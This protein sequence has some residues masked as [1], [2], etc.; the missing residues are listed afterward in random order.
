MS[1]AVQYGVPDGDHLAAHRRA[2]GRRDAAQLACCSRVPSLLVIG[3]V[4][5]RRCAATCG[6]PRRATS[7]RGRRTPA[8]TRTLTETVEGARTVEALGL[9]RPPGAGRRR[10]HRGVGAGRALHDDAAQPA[11][12]GHRR[13]LQHPARGHAAGRRLGLL[14]RLGLARAR[15]PPRCSTSRRSAVRSTGWS[16][17]STGCRS[18]PPRRA[19]CSASPRCRRT[20]SRAPRV[21]D[22]PGAGRRGPPLRLPRGPRRAARRRP[23][24]AH[25]RAAGDRRA[26]RGSGKSTLGRLLS[27]INGPRTGSVT[28][29]GVDLVALPLETL[30][31]EVALVTQEHHVFVGSVRDNIVLGPRGLRR[32]GGVGGAA[33]GRLRAT[34]S[35]GC[36]TGS[37]PRSAP[38]TSR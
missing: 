23:R 15:S 24:P 6:A 9:A 10:R 11:V 17:R 38:A 18:A 13:R 4:V 16:A 36:P 3:V 7:P 34:G 2:L 26:R 32:R 28:V 14:A 22:G 5:R 30:R 21:P 29:G 8:S 1:R 37:T 33:R 27:G 19:G 35:S 25:R 31:T 20:G 12:R